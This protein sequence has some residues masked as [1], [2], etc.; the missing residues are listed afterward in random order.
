MPIISLEKRIEGLCIGPNLTDAK[1]ADFIERCRRY[2]PFITCIIPNPH[3]IGDAVEMLDGSGIEVAGAIAYPLGNL[4]IE[5]KRTQIE[6]ALEA[7]ARQIDLLVR[8]ESLNAGDETAARR[9]AESQIGEPKGPPRPG[10]GSGTSSL[11]GR[12]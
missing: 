11:P 8:V 12:G 2:Q 5:V 4:A 9:E 6:A 3:Q 10:E 1:L 7:G